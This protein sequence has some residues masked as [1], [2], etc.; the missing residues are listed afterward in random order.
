MSFEI[1]M[2]TRG[3]DALIRQCPD[4]ADELALTLGYEVEAK[5]KIHAPVDTGFMKNNID[6]SGPAEQG[7]GQ[8]LVTSAAEYSE[9]VEYGTSR[10]GAQPFMTPAVAEV[11]ATQ[12][13]TAARILNKHI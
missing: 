3:L 4:I 12:T 7:P 8:A 9:H 1:Q 11:E 10:M 2:D 13:E 5:A 6:T